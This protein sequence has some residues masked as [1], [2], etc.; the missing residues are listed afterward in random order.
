MC[1]FR[2][3]HTGE[4]MGKGKILPSK[5]MLKLTTPIKDQ[6]QLPISVAC[7]VAGVMEDEVNQ[8]NAIDREVVLW[9]DRVDKYCVAH[10]HGHRFYVVGWT[11]KY[12]RVKDSWT[13]KIIRWGKKKLV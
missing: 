10:L 7:V 11:L 8:Q 5:F 12:V 1:D 2:D 4:L 9:Q 6:G 3:M 13:G